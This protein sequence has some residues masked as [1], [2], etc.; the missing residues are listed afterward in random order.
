METAH[1]DERVAIRD[2][3]AALAVA[4]KSLANKW[5]E[6]GLCRERPKEGGRT[7]CLKA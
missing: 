7:Q 5:S 3:A 6:L 2:L 4:P 1:K